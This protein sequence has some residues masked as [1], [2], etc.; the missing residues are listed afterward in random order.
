MLY[1]DISSRLGTTSARL[2]S[3]FCCGVGHHHNEIRMCILGVQQR[4]TLVLKSLL[5]NQGVSTVS[6][7]VCMSETG[8]FHV[9]RASDKYPEVTSITHTASRDHN[10]FSA[11]CSAKQPLLFFVQPCHFRWPLLS[12]DHITAC[13]CQ[14]NT[15]HMK[16]SYC[17]PLRQK[18]VVGCVTRML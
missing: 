17:S 7:Y 15:L 3:V 11:G 4:Y 18:I 10:Q 6:L 9:S 13:Q 5:S 12:H 16:S 14:W 8:Q 2:H 1:A